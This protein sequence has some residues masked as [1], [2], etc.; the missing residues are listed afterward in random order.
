MAEYVG[1]NQNNIDIEGL[2]DRHRTLN[3]E[4]PEEVFIVGCGGTG[5]WTALLC[6]MVG[7][8]KIHLFDDDIVENS[9]RSRLPYPEEWIGMKKTEALKS[10]INWI[11]PECD[12]YTYGGII[13]E[14]DL[15]SVNGKLVFD[16]NDDPKVQKWVFAHCKQNNFNYVGIG[17]N[18][19]H[20]TVISDLDTI[21]LN[22]NKDMYQVTPMYIVPPM[23]AVLYAVW[24]VVHGNKDLNFLRSMESI[25]GIQ[26]R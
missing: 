14:I 2:Y 17:C 22:E 25:F 26:T 20:V 1:E 23:L 15:I 13:S 12:V 9:N 24:N 21:F 6:A 8:K 10:F 11:R 4:I 7:V 18:A 3:L 5:T 19:N 16:C